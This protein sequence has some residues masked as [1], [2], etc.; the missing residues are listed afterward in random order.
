MTKKKNDPTIIIKK[1]K[2]VQIHFCDPSLTEQTHKNACDINT[3]VNKFIK[4]GIMP[5]NIG[6]DPQYGFAPNIDFK[7]ALDIVKNTR[8]EFDD[9]VD[10]EKALFDHNSD[11]YAEF[12]INYDEG[13][14]SFE[15]ESPAKPD[16]LGQELP[17]DPPT[18]ST[19]PKE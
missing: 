8:R 2:R 6:P 10:S 17:K 15:D 19:D 7:N 9:L 12:L 1:R 11:K 18:D 13:S 4:T 16:T 14:L 3:I 5:Q